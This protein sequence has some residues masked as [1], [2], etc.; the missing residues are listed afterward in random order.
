[1]KKSHV[2]L[3]V[4]FYLKKNVTRDGLCPVMGRI[5]LGKEMVQFS[6]K[7]DASPKLWDARA[8][9]VNGKSDHAREV[10][11]EIDK[12][13]VAIHARY[14]EIVALK[15]M[16]TATEV[17]EAYQ[18]IASSQV[19]VLELFGEHNSAFEKMVG[20]NRAIRTWW[21]YRNAYGH[22][23]KFISTKYRVRDIPVRQLDLSFIEDYDYFL[24]IDCRQMPNTVLCNVTPLRRI[25]NIAIKKSII[26]RDPFSGYSPERPE[27]QHRYL[28]WEDLSKMMKTSFSSPKL[29]F[30]RDM[31]VFSCF[32]GL[33]FSDL[34]QLTPEQLVKTDDGTIWLM[35]NRQ[36]TDTPSNVPLLDIPL[37]IIEKY[38]GLAKDNR[39]FPMVSC[40]LTNSYLKEIARECGIRRR[41]TFHMARH[42]FATEICT[43]HG[44]SFGTIRRMMG[45][46]KPATTLIYATATHNKVKKDGK[47]LAK[48]L[49]NKY[50]LVSVNQ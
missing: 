49:K 14:S 19:G 38:M 20:V 1:M 10:N 48:R 5:T 34:Y 25:I 40:A 4:S 32:T 27:L 16:V 8:G 28:P 41:L 18:G 47:R 3:K 6:C 42:T 33:S 26:N 2:N 39:V 21:K 29:D 44:V 31:F 24:R 37:K 15:G 17:K 46:F 35:V 30:I 12:I 13:Y 7:R 22:L 23:E 11:R 45:H 36:K 43:S 50:S 9:R